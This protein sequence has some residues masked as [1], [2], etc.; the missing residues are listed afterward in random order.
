M[1]TRQYALAVRSRDDMQVASRRH[2]SLRIVSDV[3]VLVGALTLGAR[4]HTNL[5]WQLVSRV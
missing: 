1:M 3:R 4:V 5:K 2:P